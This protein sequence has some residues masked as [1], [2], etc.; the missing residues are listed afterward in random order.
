MPTIKEF[1]IFE[2][3]QV[4]HILLPVNITFKEGNIVSKFVLN[5][6]LLSPC[7]YVYSVVYGTQ[8]ILL[9]CFVDN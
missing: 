4:V 6:S 2:K 8:I 7:I 5:I 1:Y 3:K 9:Y